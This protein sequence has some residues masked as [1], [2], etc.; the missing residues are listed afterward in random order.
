MPRDKTENNLLYLSEQ[1]VKDLD[2]PNKISKLNF[3]Y[4][5]SFV[6]KLWL[7][8]LRFLTRLVFLKV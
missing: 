8:V 4:Q 7:G 1:K 6:H 3:E 5:K 2:F